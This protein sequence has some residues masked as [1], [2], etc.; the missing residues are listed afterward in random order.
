MRKTEQLMASSHEDRRAGRSRQM[1][2]HAIM[3]LVGE[4]PY[5]KITVND[6]V[7]RANVGRSTFY[8]HFETKEDLFLSTHEPWFRQ[9]ARTFIPDDPLAP[10]EISKDLMELFETMRRD[11][12]MY[13]FISAGNA[14]GALLKTLKKHIELALEDRLKAVIG[15]E[16]TTIPLE[17][18]AKHIAGSVISVATW[19]AERHP[20]YTPEELALVLQRMNVAALREAVRKG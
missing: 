7:A 9:I 6:I 16:G 20:D 13:H 4:Q 19:W 3:D 12:M 1:L 11:P 18:L 10:A 14:N 8:A 15:A 2:Q 17:V 5:D